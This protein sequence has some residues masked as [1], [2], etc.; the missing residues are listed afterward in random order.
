MR[1]NSR[2]SIKSSKTNFIH[3]TYFPKMEAEISSETM[4]TTC[5]I[6]WYHNYGDHNTNWP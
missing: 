3:V 2:N 4:V 1:H 6:K 5:Q